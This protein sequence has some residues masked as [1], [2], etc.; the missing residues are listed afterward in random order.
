[1]P[2]EDQIKRLANRR[3]LGVLERSLGKRGRI[4]AGKQQVVALPERDLE[5]L[6]K[7]QQHLR[8]GPRT[9]GLDEAEMAGRDAGIER[10]LQ[11]AEPLSLAPLPQQRPSPRSGVH[12]RRHDARL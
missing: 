4:A 11:L 3:E 10:E 1:M 8:A 12:G 5:L 7:Q 6:C 2:R 9:P